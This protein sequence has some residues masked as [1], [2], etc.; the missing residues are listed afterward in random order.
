LRD[1]ADDIDRAANE[2]VDPLERRRGFGNRAIGIL[3]R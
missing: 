1:Q 3:D 2:I